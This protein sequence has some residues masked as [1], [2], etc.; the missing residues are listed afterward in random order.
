MAQGKSNVLEAWLLF[1]VIL[2]WVKPAVSY[3]IRYKLGMDDKTR[4]IIVDADPIRGTLSKQYNVKVS[5]SAAKDDIE[6]AQSVHNH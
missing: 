1:F 4:W 6:S 5:K 3:E 2:I